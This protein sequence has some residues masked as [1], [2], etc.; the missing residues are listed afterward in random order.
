MFELA[1][2]GSFGSHLLFYFKLYCLN[3]GFIKPFSLSYLS[4][5]LGSKSFVWFASPGSRRLE[6]VAASELVENW[7]NAAVGLL[8]GDVDEAD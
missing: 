7:A 4:C 3:H 2:I 1:Y 8:D 6:P 5:N